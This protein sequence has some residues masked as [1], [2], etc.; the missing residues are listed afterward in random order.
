MSELHTLAL[1]H[2]K[3]LRQDMTNHLNAL[4]QQQAEHTQTIKGQTEAIRNLELR[5][6][7][8]EKLLRHLNELYNHLLPLIETINNDVRNES[9]R[10]NS[11]SLPSPPA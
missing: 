2:L 6:G 1:E 4:A 7:E 3:E 10:R 5:Q 8:F 9:Q 11:D